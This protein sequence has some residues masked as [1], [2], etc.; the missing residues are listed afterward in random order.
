[1]ISANHSRT[2]L[3]GLGGN[4]GDVL[5][6]FR[7]AAERLARDLGALSLSTVYR[8]PPEGGVRQPPYLNAVAR[9]ET[10]VTPSEL[11]QLVGVVEGA[12]GRER[13]A[14]GAAR[15]LDV[16]ILFLG[17]LIVSSTNLTLPHPRW[18]SRDFVVVPLLDVA[19][20]WI[21]PVTGRAAR[22][23]AS[24]RGWS[25]DRFAVVAPGVAIGAG[26]KGG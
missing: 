1:L 10:T 16:D 13:P 17:D 21:D 14:P 18:S 23:I 8:T 26:S 25:S 4:L 12:A 22:E 24:E 11:L 5:A 20:E 19:P 6:A 15:S 2:A 3:L 9:V 7:N